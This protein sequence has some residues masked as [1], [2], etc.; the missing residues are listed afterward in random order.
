VPSRSLKQLFSTTLAVAGLGVWAA[1][2]PAQPPLDLPGDPSATLSITT[3][4]TDAAAARPGPGP[5]TWPENPQPLPPPRNVAA[6]SA[7]GF[8]WGDAGIGA[9]G[10]VA[11][12]LAGF[13][14]V[15]LVRR[16]H[17]RALPA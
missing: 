3:R 15:A 8:D 11:V 14:A 12:L 6:N 7:D 9:G 4:S 13:G 17:T 5:P 10:A 2:A 1:G 16:R